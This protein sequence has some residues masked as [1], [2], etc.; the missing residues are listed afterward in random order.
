MTDAITAS[1]SRQS[2]LLRELSVIANNVANA[3]T[4]GFR[5]EAA[6]FAE[7]VSGR[8]GDASLSMGALRAHA[9][10]LSQGSFERTGGTLDFAIEGPGWFGIER[11]GEMFL[12][13]SG[14]FQTDAEGQIVTADGEILLDDGGGAIFLPQGAINIE[15][16]RDG[17]LTADGFGVAQLGVFRADPLDLQ[18]AGGNLW[19]NDGAMEVDENPSIRQGFLE[20]SNVSPVVEMARLIEA[21]RAYEAGAA[22]QTNEDERVRSLIEALERR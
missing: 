5:R 20:A 9:P 3:S 22:L 12:T 2:G 19:R 8:S 21:Q 1:L 13:R 16:S 4:D 11:G 15:V 18:R 7:Y 17:T 14:H 6:I 10:D